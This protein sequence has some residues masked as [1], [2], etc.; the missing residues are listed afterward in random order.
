MTDEDEG[1]AD[2]PDRN[3][4]A[5]EDDEW[6]FSLDEV[7]PEAGDEGESAE[8]G[9]DGAGA[10]GGADADGDADEEGGNVAGS[11][12]DLEEE[13]EPGTPSL[14]GTAFV[15]LGALLAVL[16]LLEAGGLL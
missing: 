6:R 9:A 3:E 15:L 8:H 10:D 4:G 12:L 1:S 11:L 16:F 2:A 7:G 14:E 13:L 5:G